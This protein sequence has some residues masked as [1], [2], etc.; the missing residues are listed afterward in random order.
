MEIKYHL[1]RVSGNSKTG[2]IPVSTTSRN[3]CP[4]ACE[5]KGSG[6]YAESGPLRLHWDAVGANRGYDL[7]KFCNEISKLPKRQLWRYGQ[8]GDLPGDGI[9]IDTESLD[10]IV[11]ASKG[12]SGF[13]FTHY[14]PTA[15]NA[16]AVAAANQAGFTINLSADDL[17]EADELAELAIGPVVVLLPEDQKKP[18]KTAGGRLVIVCPATVTKD[19]D[20]S[21]CG[22]CAKQRK[23]I[24]GFPVHGT[25]KRK[26][27]QV[28]FK[29]KPKETHATR[30]SKTKPLR[31]H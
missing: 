13:A 23:A 5:L 14:P 20:C 22:I 19:M 2:P 1:T 17:E 16:Q 25:S 26:A 31:P 29:S 9:N 10:K 4:E 6:C 27:A 8:A 15:D 18:V 28:F 24:V 30:Q 3:S 12:R 11:Q 7:D 21:V